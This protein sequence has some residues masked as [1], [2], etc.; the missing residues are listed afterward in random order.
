MYVAQHFPLVG[1]VLMLVLNRATN[2]SGGSLLFLLPILGGEGKTP[3]T[4]KVKGLV[5]LNRH[6]YIC[7]LVYIPGF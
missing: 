7:I 4:W 1:V 2:C 5:N 6:N 3:V